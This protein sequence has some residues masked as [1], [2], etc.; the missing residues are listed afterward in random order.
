MEYSNIAHMM[1]LV[2]RWYRRSSTYKPSAIADIEY[3]FV[4]T[5]C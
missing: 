1:Q 2:T 5:G 3:A 4:V